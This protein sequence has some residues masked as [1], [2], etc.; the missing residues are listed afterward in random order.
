MA[1]DVFGS[2][3]KELGAGRKSLGNK[4]KDI[5]VG[6]RGPAAFLKYELLTWLSGISGALGFALRKAFYPSLLGEVGKGVI[7]GRYLTFRHP[8]KVRIGAGTI[9]DDFAVLDAK[10]EENDGICVG[11]QAYI[12]RNAILSCKEGSIRLGDHTNISANCT[13]LSE[14][15]ITLGRYCFLAGNCYLVAGGNHSFADISKPIMHQPSL[16]KGG[17]LIGDDVWLG[18]GVIILDGVTIGSHSVVGAGSVV[19]SQLAEYAY[20]RGVRTLK[21]QDRRG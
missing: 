20:A 4:Y 18:A 10:G 1:K 7:F 6:R 11:K 15:V 5:F 8:H 3:Q 19:S 2:I 17:I 14:T 13:L 12:G 16:A 9:I 21:I